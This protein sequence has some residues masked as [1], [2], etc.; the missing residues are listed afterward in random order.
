MLE[1]CIHQL[2]EQQS[3][4]IPAAEAVRF[5][6][7]SLT[8]AE[9]DARANSFA[10]R[11]RARGVGPEK[12]VGLKMER[13]IDAVIGVLGI[14]KAGGAY[15]YLDPT[16]PQD[17]LNAMIA[18]CSP[19]AVIENIEAQTQAGRIAPNITPDNSAYLIYTSGS[20]GA[21]KG[22]VNIHRCLTARLASTP[23][24]DIRKDD[25]C[26]LS[27]ALSFGISASRL[28]LPLALGARVV[29][30]PENCVRDVE[31]YV[32]ELERN[33]VTS[34]FMVP[35][36]L[37]QVLELGDGW[38]NRLRHLRALTVSGGT[39][40]H[41]LVQACFR[42]FPDILLLNNY[43]STEI[44]TSA[45][46]RVFCRPP[47]TK[48]ISIGSPAA[49]TRISVRD[50]YG[51]TVPDGEIG[52]IHVT[53]PH[54]ARCY[55][56]QP[57]LT[58]ARF[59]CDEAGARTFR[60]G[61]LGRLLPDGEIEFLGRSDQ[62]VKIRGFR[63]ELGEIES[64]LADDPNVR[65]V[66]VTVIA[67]GSDRQLLCCLSLK[68]GTT[69][70]AGYFRETLSRRLPA[71]M[72]PAHFAFME[73]LPRTDA[74]KI[75]RSRLTSIGSVPESDNYAEPI[76]A[77]ERM[78]AQVWRDVLE[79]PRP[80]RHDNFIELGGDSLQA[81]Q[82]V[83]QVESASGCRIGIDALFSKTLAEIAREIDVPREKDRL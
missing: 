70:T 77:S 66:A 9:L 33:A 82:V 78:L 50:E 68:R 56:N 27:S 36:L 14:L 31:L 65:E 37:R 54:L 80:G 25:I 46:S 73:E 75:D 74:G 53:A 34:V 69:L 7:S 52:E 61:D 22:A 57:E 5:A 62:Q 41:E 59:L 10:G 16:Y 35:A 48:V 17:R 44:G 38:T 58:A 40:T 60:T 15:V 1:L 30:L 20:T 43:G 64:V 26:A 47:E 63:I 18:D 71:Y 12:F 83:L 42:A 29:I 23:L 81:T 79:Y 45:A 76:K 13:G 32:M 39:L 55:L 21:P 4:K 6:G 24:P 11:L 8:Y 67:G 3:D 28:F 2:I 49:N 72:I 19:A 51:R